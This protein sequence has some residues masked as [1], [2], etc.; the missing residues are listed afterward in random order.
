MQQVFG[1]V[2]QLA[3]CLEPQLGVLLLVIRSLQENRSD[4]LIAFLLGNGSK[5]GILVASLRLA[6]KRGH[7][8]LL[9]LAALQLHGEFLP[10]QSI[11][12]GI[13]SPVTVFII[14]QKL[15][16]YNSPIKK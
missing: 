3:Q 11:Y 1:R 13:A 14:P 10:V 9:S 15:Y 16:F 7:Q 2:A 5:I 12:P 6:G 4:L 8:I